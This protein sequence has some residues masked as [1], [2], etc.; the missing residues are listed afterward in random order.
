MEKLRHF[1]RFIYLFLF[2]FFCHLRRPILS[3]VIIKSFVCAC[4]VKCIYIYIYT[5]KR[6]LYCA[7]SIR[8]AAINYYVGGIKKKKKPRDFELLNCTR[9]L[10]LAVIFRAE[11]AFAG[12]A[13]EKKIRW[14]RVNAVRR[15][16]FARRVYY[17]DGGATPCPLHSTLHAKLC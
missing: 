1:H 2:S 3:A 9:P 6:L 14:L 13:N 10:R 16:I 11:K 5:L 8:A 15:R 7:Q 12:E 17:N 4:A